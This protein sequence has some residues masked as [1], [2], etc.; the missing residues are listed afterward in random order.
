MICTLNRKL[1][2][3]TDPVAGARYDI[4]AYRFHRL[5][6]FLDES[7][8]ADQGYAGPGLLTPIKR[9]AGVRMRA[10]VK[11]DNRRVNRLRPVAERVIDQIKT[12]RI[13]YTGFRRPLGSYGRVSSVVR[14][15]IFF[16][17]DPL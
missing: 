17:A 3:I 14:A 4:Y 5:E 13:L 2:V 10:I 1:L 16:A 7:T 9:K 8:L 15:L 12:W 11:E 6:R